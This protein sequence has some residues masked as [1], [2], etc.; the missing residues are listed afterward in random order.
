MLAILKKDFKAYFTSMIGWI[1]LFAFFAVSGFFFYFTTIM[2]DTSDM[3]G[4]LSMMIFCAMIV[5]PL[6]TMKL[7][8]D[9]KRLKTDQLIYTAPVKISSIVMGKFFAA[10]ILYCICILIT[11]VYALTVNVFVAPDWN[12]IILTMIGLIVTGAALIS[13]GLFFSSITESQIIAMICSYGVM[14]AI[15]LLS[16]VNSIISIDWLNSIISAVSIFDRYTSF[17]SGI[18][19]LSDLLFFISCTAVFNFFTV[20]VIEKK[21]WS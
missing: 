19:N 9:E 2:M 20:R 14:F 21:R 7:M 18:L 10:M 4:I 11:V 8:S 16:I 13:I 17:S 15:Y 12:M 5:A 6:L 3:S 1:V